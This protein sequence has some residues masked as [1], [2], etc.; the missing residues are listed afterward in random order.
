MCVH[1][2]VCVYKKLATPFTPLEYTFAID[3]DLI[4]HDIGR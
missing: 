4:I 3:S 1:V 2:Y